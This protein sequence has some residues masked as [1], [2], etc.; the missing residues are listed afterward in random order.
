MDFTRLHRIDQ[1]MANF[2]TRTKKNFQ[3]RRLYSHR[4]DK[5]SGLQ[6][7]QAI[8]LKGYYAKKDCPDKL[9]RFRHLDAETS[10]RF[11]FLTN[12]FALPALT[13]AQRYQCRWRIELFFKWIKQHLRIKKFFGTNDYAVKTQIWIAIAVCVLV[14]IVKK[15]LVLEASMYEILHV[16][17]V[18][19]FEKT[20]LKSVF[21]T[22]LHNSTQGD[23]HNQLLLFDL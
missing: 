1:A 3:F 6:C 12:N 5:S 18:M 9:R 10:N 16:L 14:A 13:I 8:V 15:E 4:I 7:D 23:S 11:V 21:S 19:L 22:D 17:G 20:P 2:V